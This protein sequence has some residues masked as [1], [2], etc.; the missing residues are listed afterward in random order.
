MIIAPPREKDPIPREITASAME[1][2]AAQVASQPKRFDGALIFIVS[3][4]SSGCAHC[5][6]TGM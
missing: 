1:K 6:E 5:L 2:P 3:I 4:N